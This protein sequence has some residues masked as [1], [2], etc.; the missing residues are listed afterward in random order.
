[1]TTAEQK[2]YDMFIDQNSGILHFIKSQFQDLYKGLVSHNVNTDDMFDSS[3]HLNQFDKDLLSQGFTTGI[4]RFKCIV[5]KYASLK[6]DQLDGYIATCVEIQ[7]KET[8]KPR[9]RKPFKYGE[10]KQ[11]HPYQKFQDF[12]TIDIGRH[13]RSNNAIAN[14]LNYYASIIHDI[15]YN[16]FRLTSEALAKNPKLQRFCSLGLDV[17]SGL[18][19]RSGIDMITMEDPDMATSLHIVLGNAEHYILRNFKK[20]ADV[21]IALRVECEIATYGLI[22]E[23]YGN[24]SEKKLH[25]VR[26]MSQIGRE[27]SK[28]AAIIQKVYECYKVYYL[29][30]SHDVDT[31]LKNLKHCISVNL[32]PFFSEGCPNGNQTCMV[33]GGFGSFLKSI[34]KTVYNFIIIPVGKF[35]LLTGSVVLTSISSAVTVLGCGYLLFAYF[36]YGLFMLDLVM[37]MLVDAMPTAKMFW[38]ICKG[39]GQL[40]I[41][42][43]KLVKGSWDIMW[44]KGGT[45]DKMMVFQH[46]ICLMAVQDPEKA[47]KSFSNACNPS[48]TYTDNDIMTIKSVIDFTRLNEGS[49]NNFAQFLNSLDTLKNC[50]SAKTMINAVKALPDQKEEHMKILA[51]LKT[52]WESNDPNV[53]KNNG[54]KTTSVGGR[55]R[56]RRS[57]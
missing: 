6:D 16:K 10:I 42:S 56:T 22:D 50:E 12:E 45:S 53:M 2:V 34:A 9:N 5:A 57:K 47:L 40:T 21:T 11:F 30:S 1:M 19:S 4:K 35:M 37:I 15:L 14:G 23:Q 27:S 20:F 13:M 17:K 29:S 38:N 7:K 44:Q 43:T 51:I 39:L 46:A 52:Q 54:G 32:E 28:L 3:T 25:L 26:A 31:N 18:L 49:Q 8:E 41:G 48:Y 55:R 24:D 33:G 36:K